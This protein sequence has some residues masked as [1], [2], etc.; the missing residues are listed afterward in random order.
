ML[1]HATAL[2]L[3]V[4]SSHLSMFGSCMDANQLTVSP[5]ASWLA[6]LLK[7]II[8]FTCVPEKAPKT[9]LPLKTGRPVLRI[10]VR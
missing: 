7:W 9:Y 3:G 6:H 10:S 4:D 5:T 2:A 8:E 1:D